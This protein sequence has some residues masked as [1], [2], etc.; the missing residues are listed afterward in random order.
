MTSRSP[1]LHV[2]EVG[3]RGEVG[4]HIFRVRTEQHR[5]EEQP[6]AQTVDPSGGL[7]VLGPRRCGRDGV[8]VQGDAD[9]GVLTLPAHRVHGKTVSEQEVVRRPDGG[10]R[11]APPGCV[12]PRAVPEEGRAP[13][14]IE[15]GE[16]AHP[17][18]ERA[19]D[20]CGVVGEAGRGVA[21]RPA[22]RVLDRLRQVPVV[23]R[24]PRLDAMAEQLVDQPTVEVQTGRVGRAGAGG[25]HPRPGHREPVRPQ[26]P[27]ASSS[28]TSSR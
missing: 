23:E 9:L 18:A 28:A 26:G 16:M 11:F 24:Q 19:M 25:L 7:L 1:S 10:R 6:V 8:Q 14:F 17:V 15:R 27:C 2:P 13:R 3:N 4:E 12:M 22:A 5:V 20:Q 21:G